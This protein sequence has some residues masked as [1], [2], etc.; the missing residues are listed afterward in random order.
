MEK[1]LL[2]NSSGKRD[3]MWTLSVLAFLIVV[4]RLVTGMVEEVNAF[5]MVFKIRE[6][7]GGVIAALLGPTFFSYI[8]RKNGIGKSQK[9]ETNE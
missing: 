1:L 6:L 2:K 9:E 7:D 3:G 8:A 4:F 5:N